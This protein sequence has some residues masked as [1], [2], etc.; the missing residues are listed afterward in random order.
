MSRIGKQPVVLPSGCTAEIRDG[1][2]RIQGKLGELTLALPGGVGVKEEGGVLVVSCEG[3]GKQA[4]AHYGTTRAHLA[5]MV[6]GVTEGYVK[7][8]EIHGVG[9]RASARGRH[10]SLLVGFSHSVEYD[11]PETVEVE[12]AGDGLGIKVSG[13]DKQQVGLVAARIRAFQPPEPY[14]GKGIR[15]KGEN[16]RR[17][18]GKTVA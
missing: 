6:K 10:L 15:Y 17:K 16:V 13:T 12:V 18:V 1:R 5:N 7:E 9:F 14:K 3:G 2:V 8:L 4:S 11:A